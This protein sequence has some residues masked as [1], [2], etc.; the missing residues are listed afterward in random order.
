MGKV[1]S[2]V[3]LFHVMFPAALDAQA[4][5]EPWAR[6]SIYVE[7]FGNALF[8]G[9]LNFDRLVRAAVSARAGVSP[10]GAGV[11]M[12]NYLHGN[13]ANRLE[14]GA[15]ILVSL[16]SESSAPEGSEGVFSCPACEN[17]DPL[18]GGNLLG[19]ATLG[20]RHQPTAGGTVLRAGLSPAIGRRGQVALWFGISAGYAF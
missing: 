14:A 19:T 15:G 2:T 11:L 10:F 16:R 17:E 8:G 7:A 20:Y 5:A 13:G 18:S 3:L 12:G 4:P 1:I 9:S 6:N